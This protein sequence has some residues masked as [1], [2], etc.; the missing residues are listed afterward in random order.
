[1]C[2]QTL[3]EIA[4]SF[5]QLLPCTHLGSWLRPS[6]AKQIGFCVSAL[7]L[8]PRQAN[9]I[10]FLSAA[11]FFHVLSFL[12]LGLTSF[13]AMVLTFALL[14]YNH[15]WFA[16]IFCT[17]SRIIIINNRY[18]WRFLKYVWCLDTDCKKTQCSQAS[19]IDPPNTF[20]FNSALVRIGASMVLHSKLGKG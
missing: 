19:C 9:L 2:L 8:F 14:L 1:M 20:E 6:Q 3:E 15:V 17:E 16:V 10:L 4:I 18:K 11:A 13:H 7:L 12:S 5:I